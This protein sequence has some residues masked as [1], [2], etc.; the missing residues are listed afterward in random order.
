M[1]I[2]TILFDLDGTLLPMDQ[3]QFVNTYLGLL[4]KKMAPHG[5]DPKALVDAV[6]QGT[7]AMMKNT[8]KKTNEAVFWDTFCGLLGQH[9]R[10]DEPLFQEFYE[11]EFSGVQQVCG[12]SPKA[13]AVIALLKS[14]GF[15]AALATNPLFPAVATRQRITWAGLDPQDFELYT[16]YED[17]HY[18][19]PNPA[20]YQEVLDR[21]GIKAEECVMVGND[22]G[23]DMVAQ[24]LG[25]KVFLLT[26]CILNPKG[27]P[28]DQYPQG[29]FDDLMAF[30]EHL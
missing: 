2:T 4:A 22:V 12:C 28:C 21:L 25:M 29:N 18:C 14:R 13:A 27:L 15:R 23:E 5:Y 9:C 26:D 17:Y 1:G 24:T 16:T 8:G 7:K 10:N 11:N 30:I 3:I 19:K 20:Y 6:W